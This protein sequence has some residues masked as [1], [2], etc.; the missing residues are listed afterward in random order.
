MATK[1]DVPPPRPPA[2][3]V[4]QKS[5]AASAISIR[6][7]PTDDDSE[8]DDLTLFGG[9]SEKKK[10]S[11]SFIT[12]KTNN[13]PSNVPKNFD[14]APCVNDKKNAGTLSTLHITS[15]SMDDDIFTTSIPKEKL[16]ESS[17]EASE[18]KW[19][20]LSDIRG[21][22]TDKIAEPIA[23]IS[24]KWDE[25]SGESGSSPENETEKSI[26][27]STLTTADD[28]PLLH[29][30]PLDDETI[31][32]MNGEFG[33][34]DNRGDLK[35]CNDNTNIDEAVTIVD[36][37]FPSEPIDD[38]SGSI[39]FHPRANSAPSQVRSRSKIKKLIPTR[40]P[41][42]KTEPKVTLSTLLNR[43]VSLDSTDIFLDAQ[44]SISN[45]SSGSPADS[46]PTKNKSLTDK[47]DNSPN[48][49][50]P[51]QKLIVLVFIIFGYLIIPLPSYLSG[52]IMGGVLVS[53]GW[54]LFLWLTKPAV[55]HPPVVLETLDKL[56]PLTVPEMK[57]PKLDDG[58]YKVGNYL[59]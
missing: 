42:V 5:K 23:A 9:S 26:I 54:T 20:T 33:D 44:D 59:L 27:E 46:S 45:N 7:N 48:Y 35:E 51:F 10:E 30:D 55:A 34:D 12:T 49:A 25:I 53:L 38:Y 4:K 32:E 18:E 1:K 21:K 17:N 39:T 6:F 58:I 36:N 57:E 3:K 19:P 16:P 37:F 2:P 22:I 43:N 40:Q 13:E 47:I 41:P 52:M 8:D 15:K 14:V 31:Y 24:R 11:V 50:V 56:P 28:H 29:T